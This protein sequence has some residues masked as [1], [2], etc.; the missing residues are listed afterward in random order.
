MP[1]PTT[2]RPLRTPA[3]VLAALAVLA[4]SATPAAA[5]NS[6]PAA[7]TS[8]WQIHDAA[9]PGLD[10]GSVR[11]VTQNPLL[12]FGS[13]RVKVSPI[14]ATDPSAR[15]NGQMLRGFGLTFDGVD[16]FET[17]SAVRLGG[18]AVARD[19]L[20]KRTANW[21]RWL[22]TFTNTTTATKTVEVSFGGAAGQNTGT[23]QSRVLASG[24]GDL[25]IG[26][27]DAWVATGGVASTVANPA[28]GPA[29]GAPSAVVLGTPAPFTGALAGT[30]VHQRDPFATPLP[31]T[32][33]EANFYG[34]RNTL[35]L[36]PGETK[37][38]L[39]YVVIGRTETAGTAGTQIS[40]TTTAAA[41]LAA[42]PDVTGLTTGEVCELANWD[43]ATIPNFDPGLCAAIPAPEPP[44]AQPV[45]A[46][47]RTTSPYDVVGRSLSEIKADLEA[48][49]TTS[50]EVVRAY[51]DRI[52][53]YDGGPY[54]FKAFIHLN[55]RA[56]AQAR[57]AD[58]ARAA[59]DTRPLLGIPLALKDNYDT[60]D[61]PTTN[62][63]LALEGYVPD[64]DAGQVAKLRAAG[65]IFIGKANLSEFANSGGFSE[66]GWGQTWNA[67]NP[68]KTSFG[69]SGGTAVAIASSMAAAGLG[70]Q[71]G[72]SLYAPSTG[73]GLA[74]LRATD[75]MT[76]GAG[77]APLTFLQDHGGPIART[78][79][80]LALLLN[81]TS[82]TDPDDVQTVDADAD[83]RRPADWTTGLRKDALEGKR[84][85][86]VAD[87]FGT[88]YGDPRTI[89]AVRA[90][91]TALTAAGATVVE[92]PAPPAAPTTAQGFPQP[93]GAGRRNEGW[94]RYFAR[95]ASPPFTTAAGVLS[96]PKVLPYN[97]QTLTDGPGLTDAEV[98][99]ILDYRREYKRRLDQWMT[100]N[101]VDAVL[102]P[103]F[104]SENF[105]N[106]GATLSSDRNS[107]IPVSNAGMPTVTL[108]VGLGPS[109]DPVSLQILGRSFA[110]ATVLG[111]GYALEQRL[112]L[113]LV[114]P[115][116]PKLAYDASAQPLEIEQPEPAPA[117]VTPAPVQPPSNA[118]P[119][120]PA[121]APA[122]PRG[123]I[124]LDL[125]TTAAGLRL[126]DGR[127]RVTVVNRDPAALLT[128]VTLRAR[129]GRSRVTIGRATVRTVAGAQ[130]TARI[131]LTRSARRALRPGRTLRVTFVVT[132]L[133]ADGR[134]RSVNTVA[135][136]RR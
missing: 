124:A 28:A 122:V 7:N 4:G 89:D 78:V 130:R 68:S 71:T 90:S 62:G 74:T 81:V 99:Q 119:G 6:V 53:A 63:T 11:A 128:T 79:E 3:A 117:P 70:S 31:T 132:S 106:D 84:F 87:A 100:D 57:A 51:L 27:E 48:G 54:G 37:T 14:A 52:G 45:L 120:T 40:A 135:T 112:G 64:R 17:T 96:S 9:R 34:Y 23:G 12:G 75:G 111:Y 42:T 30:G 59:G 105:D 95:S 69:S 20:V 121:P 127:V 15:L 134:L 109:G 60:K 86:F 61:M 115:A 2:S 80:D 47:A 76:S 46:L 102:Y 107:G 21:A 83:A 136:V 82:G 32:G 36:A 88:T 43:L 29:L 72:V 56:M 26:P 131:L 33:M 97:R 110:D 77:I 103:G 73:N 67:W 8:V 58:E 85:G 129:V 1:H 66:S 114:S 18:V 24:S 22:D 25:T 5:V 94:K 35:T 123:R 116:S 113:R 91:F 118:G 126:R 98:T 92:I 104:R 101:A 41:G 49:R 55:E 16:R 19:V 10:T 50:Q 39:R 65:A 13:I 133:D 125:V 44:S 38:L 93:A 108:P